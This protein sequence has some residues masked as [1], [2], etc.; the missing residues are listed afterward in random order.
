MRPPS[1]PPEPHD[2]APA[3]EAAP[4][5]CLLAHRMFAAFANPIF[6]RAEADG[7]P[8]MIVSL[9]DREAGLPLR[10]LQREFGIEDDTPDGRMLALIAEALDFVSA[11]RPGDDL[12][13]E[14]LTGAASWK[15]DPVHVALANTRLRLQLVTWLTAGTGGDRIDL[16]SESLLQV[17]DDP[18]L[19]AQVQLA[20]GRAAGALGLSHADQVLEMLEALGEELGYIEALRDRLLGRL[21]LTVAK[22]ERVAAGWH[23]SA[24][25]GETVTQVRRLAK[26][27][28]QQVRNRFEEL[29]A[30][31][32]EVLAMLR[33]TDSQRTFI[34][35]NRD[36]L[37]RSL[38]GWEPI[39]T[40]WDGAALAFD[41][42]MAALIARTYQ[43]LAPRF[44]PV[45]EWLS[46]TRPGRPKPTPAH[47]V[48]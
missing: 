11:L 5:R 21:T 32:G 1:T 6:R 20:H 19:R 46:S 22:I 34:R 47:M 33:N 7:A 14:V 30:Q 26:T 43:F 2:P 12:P 45:T 16:T 36:W 48:W 24:R 39:L 35:C 42:A 37:Y 4:D 15:P 8:V 44:M 41:A 25:H 38:R 27:A 31:T 40:S 9:G 10:S 17:A 3:E 13:S 18:S 28:L 29:D 23:G